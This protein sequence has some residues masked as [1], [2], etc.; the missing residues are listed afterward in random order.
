MKTVAID[1]GYW[2]TKVLTKDDNFSFRS[3][4]EKASDTLSKNNTMNLVYNDESYLVGEG[5]TQNNIELDKTSNELHKICT[6]AALS[7]LSN[8]IGTE[9]N[10]VASYPLSMYFSD[11]EAYAEYLRTD[12]FIQTTLGGEMKLFKNSNVTVFPQCVAAL[13][14][15]P[16]KYKNKVWGVLDLGGLTGIGCIV[17]NLNLIRET[18]FTE[19]LGGIILQNKIK[20]ALDNR[21][22][23]NIKDYEIQN[24]IKNGLRK[25]IELSL[26]II[27]EVLYGHVEEIRKVM[28]ANGWNIE[29]LDILL[30]GGT[31][32]TLENQLTDMLKYSCL[33][34][35][36]INE[37][38][39]GLLQI[40]EMIY[41]EDI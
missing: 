41:E 15:N 28:R 29:N 6:Y 7:R 14:N 12:D 26:K 40:G 23:L 4:I 25:D 13:Y 19:N 2:K 10:T 9:F 33:S 22:G 31:S 37:N 30:I 27:N 39:K 11:S 3:K 8:Y 32:I 17:E 5:A 18:A 21:F 38:V 35:D 34:Q 20:K 36:P 24:I 16:D 1:N